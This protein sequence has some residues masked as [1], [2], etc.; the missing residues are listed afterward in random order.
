[1][2][3]LAKRKTRQHIDKSTSIAAANLIYWLVFAGL[4]G[5]ILLPPFFR[6]LFFPREQ[7][8]AH[9]ITLSLFI[10]WWLRRYML[11]QRQGFFNGPVDAAALLLVVAYGLSYLV[12]VNQRAAIG[13]LLKN[14]N[15]FLLLWLITDLVKDKRDIKAF[16][17]ALVVTGVATSILAFGAAAGQIAYEG[18][19]AGS[20][21]FSCFQY[22]NTFASYLGSVII[23]AAGLAVESNRLMEKLLLGAAGG[24]MG[25]AFLFTQSRGAVLVIPVAALGTILIMPRSKRL[26]AFWYYIAIAGATLAVAGPL[27]AALT[28]PAELGYLI[29]RQVGM[30]T[31]LAAAFSSLVVLIEK[32]FERYQARTVGLATAA[33]VLAALA[34]VVSKLGLS[35]L[36]PANVLARFKTIGLS[37]KGAAERI[38]WT[39]DAFRIIKDRFLLGAGGG[40]WEA[41]Y[42]QYQY[43]LY[44]SN[45]VHNHWLQTWVEV[46][47]LGFLAF[48]ALWGA[49]FYLGLQ[50]LRKSTDVGLKVLTAAILGAILNLGIHSFIDFNLSL[51]AVALALWA[52]FA[53]AQTAAVQT[54]C[55]PEFSFTQSRLTWPGAVAMVLAAI[56]IVGTVPLLVGLKYG[57]QGA[58]F[59]GYN[60]IPFAIKRYEQAIKYD[61]LN[62]SYKI[63][64]A[65][66]LEKTG[67]KKE[68]QRLIQRA[69]DLIRE[70]QELEPTNASFASLRAAMVFR[71]GF[72]DEGLHYAERAVELRHRDP[73][74]YEGLA[75]A[76]VEAARYWQSKGNHQQAAI[77]LEKLAAIP[78]NIETL[79]AHTPEQFRT[80]GQPPLTVTLQLKLYVGVGYHLQDKY[81]QATEILQPLTESKDKNLQAEAKLWLGLTAAKRGDTATAQKLIQEALQMRPELAGQIQ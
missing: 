48:A 23:I 9:L 67:Q 10:L 77:A 22:P 38:W 43:Y 71:Y 61:R 60:N 63:D 31:I 39:K 28:Q 56:T 62:A 57:Q 52:L 78:T 5:L 6:G 80:M 19:V 79:L 40:G 35:Q 46:G 70:G 13:E 76:Y 66:C 53:L 7:L 65:Q 36:L 50:V 15:Y 81:Q 20:R 42:Q 3:Y 47:T 18:A 25:L 8:I 29:W 54:R 51:S 14:L 41:L 4:L 2:S 11:G 37:T 58:K 24:L 1:M 32:I 27:G 16:L 49:V 44:W 74:Q 55:L 68:S 69:L 17:W 26:P 21:L 33:A 59:M 12:A 30:G 75:Q 34:L 72:I 64:L 73:A 45:Q